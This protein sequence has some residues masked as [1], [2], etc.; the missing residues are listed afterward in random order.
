MSVNSL[1]SVD[2]S[3]IGDGSDG[4]WS[5]VTAQDISIAS[6]TRGTPFNLM[7]DAP[8]S[9]N[10]I[11]FEISIVEL[12]GNIA[13]GVVKKDEF[14]P[15]WK[16]K[17]MFYNGNVSNGGAA[18]IVGFGD[19]LKANDKV[20]VYLQRETSGVL[21]TVFFINEVCLGP[22]FRLVDVDANQRWYPCIHVSGEAQ[23][24][25]NVPEYL[26]ETIERQS[27]F[28]LGS[29]VGD[30]K[31][32]QLFSGPELIEFPL[33]E[34]HVIRLTFQEQGPN[35]YRLVTK[36]GNT[37]HCQVEI[38]GKLEAFDRIR[39][40]RVASTLMLP[41]PELRDVEKLIGESLPTLYKMII[42]DNN[43]IMTGPTIEFIAERYSKSF[44]PLS[45]Y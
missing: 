30:W 43:L 14:L 13:V 24:A 33:P 29:Y 1:V 15:G 32:I 27:V 12:N 5:A 34:G 28:Q 8:V 16:T 39:V 17:G 35:T 4:T 2:G 31:L 23:V 7:F 3:W 20:G 37:M 18:L 38:V 42:S 26:P 36:V 41:P 6:A 45:N 10:S 11:F 21:Q 25:F 22:A 40:G 19:H 44:E 9:P